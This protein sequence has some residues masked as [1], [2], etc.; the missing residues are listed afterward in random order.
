VFLQAWYA[1]FASDGVA[2]TSTCCIW[3]LA[4][5]ETRSSRDYAQLIT[6]SE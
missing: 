1:D 6:I 5:A 4:H 3:M 2:V